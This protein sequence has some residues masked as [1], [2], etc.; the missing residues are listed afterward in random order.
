MSR[1]NR[2][3]NEPIQAGWNQALEPAGVGAAFGQYKGMVD[4]LFGGKKK[5]QTAKE[6]APAD[7]SLYRSVTDK[8]KLKKRLQEITVVDDE[9]RQALELN[10]KR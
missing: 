2:G 10:R 3:F 4:Q 5:P 1:L 6:S 9:M 7:T 8:E